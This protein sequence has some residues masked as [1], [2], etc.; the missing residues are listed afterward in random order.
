MR[1]ERVVQALQSL[2]EPAPQEQQKDTSDAA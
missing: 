2:A 1:M